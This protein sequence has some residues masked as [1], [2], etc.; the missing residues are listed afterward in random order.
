MVIEIPQ[1]WGK[2]SEFEGGKPV[3]TCKYEI[4]RISSTASPVNTRYFK[5]FG[6]SRYS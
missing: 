3:V 5:F 4:E 6:N 1:R 2:Y